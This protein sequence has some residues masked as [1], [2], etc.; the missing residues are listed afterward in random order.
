MT[1]TQ[2]ENWLD[3]ATWRL[4][5]DSAAQVRAEI[6]EHYELARQEE[7]SAGATADEADRRAVAEL[8]DAETANCQY[9]KVLLTATEARVLR[10][11]NWEARAVCSQ[12][13]VKWIMLAIPL[14]ALF[15][16]MG[17]RLSGAT[18]VARVLVIMGGGMAFLFGVPF[19]P[20]YTPSRA[21]IFRVARW[22]VMIAVL[23]LA[24]GHDALKYS[25]LL[26]SCLWP[27]FWVDWQRAS[28]RRKL[29]VAEWP[30]QL[31]R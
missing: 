31:Y 8:G 14:A 25:W 18:A 28:I 3:R 27:M 4:A 24:F 19:L 21:R 23:L 29:P 11:G 12:M 13:W 6:R 9:R 17:L 1:V 16:A 5:K 22:A 26:V 10:Q 30:K 2:L 20:V 7:M 15:A